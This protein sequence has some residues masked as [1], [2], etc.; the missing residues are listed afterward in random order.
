MTRTLI[1]IG[2]AVLVVMVICVTILIALEKDPS[3][4]IAFLIAAIVPTITSM[5]GLQ[6]I[7]KVQEVAEEAVHNT[8]GRMTQI[9]EHS[10]EVARENGELKLQ[11]A[12]YRATGVS[13]NEGVDS[14]IDH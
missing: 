8:N 5:F 12:A 1:G 3:T 10:Q 4:L 9:I 2:S 13:I 11:L 7:A 6:K 14:D